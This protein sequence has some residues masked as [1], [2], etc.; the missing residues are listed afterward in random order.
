V[1]ALDRLGITTAGESRWKVSAPESLHG[2]Y[3]GAFGGFLAATAVAVAR[4]LAPGRR[5]FTLDCQ[6]IRGLRGDNAPVRAEIVRSGRSMSVVAVTISDSGDVTTRATVLLADPGSLDDWNVTDRGAPPAGTATA[7]AWSHPPDRQVGIIDTL[8]PRANREAD[9]G[10][11]TTIRTPWPEP[12]CDA[13]AEVACMAADLATG[14]PVEA[15]FDGHWRPHPN[16]DLS[17]RFLPR[18]ITAGEVTGVGTLD[19]SVAGVAMMS[20]AVWAG[21]ER[22]AVGISTSLVSAPKGAGGS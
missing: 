10:I 13:S 20:L 3:G 1:S 6:F 21:G 7:K 5:P 9:G 8:A 18:P 17:L 2:A 11:A 12:D 4:E 15:S 19:G 14:P 22:I 16:P